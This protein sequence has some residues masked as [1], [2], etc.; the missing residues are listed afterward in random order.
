[1]I[2]STT[3]TVT[4]TGNVILFGLISIWILARLQNSLFAS[5]EILMT[6]PVRWTVVKDFIRR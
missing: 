6:I 3:T 2:N 5:M 1:M 4:L